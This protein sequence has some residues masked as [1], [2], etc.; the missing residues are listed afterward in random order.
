MKLIYK[1]AFIALLLVLMGCA[2]KIVQNENQIRT[3][4][5]QLAK[6]KDN[7]KMLQNEYESYKLSCS[8]LDNYNKMQ[9]IV[10]KKAEPKKK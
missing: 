8:R 5:I 7:E 6:Q 1:I 10:N 2:F 9:E 3:L 4:N